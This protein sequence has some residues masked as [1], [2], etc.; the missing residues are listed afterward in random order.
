M[1]ASI[2]EFCLCAVIEL[3]DPVRKI[4]KER[5]MISCILRNVEELKKRETE[6]TAQ[7][8]EHLKFDPT[9]KKEANDYND[10]CFMYN[11]VHIASL[12]KIDQNLHPALKARLNALITQ[13][14][15]QM[16]PQP[17]AR[18][19]PVVEVKEQAS[20]PAFVTEIKESTIIRPIPIIIRQPPVPPA[21]PAPEPAP[22]A[23]EPAQAASALVELAAQIEEN[24]PKRPHEE[25]E[26]ERKVR[27]KI[28]PENK[29][30]VIKLCK[31]IV[32][33]QVP[34]DFR[35]TME[36]VIKLCELRQQYMALTS[37]K[38]ETQNAKII[39]ET[40]EYLQV[41]ESWPLEKVKRMK[42]MYQQ[43]LHGSKAYYRKVLA[44]IIG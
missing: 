14:R 26:Q 44:E 33:I 7:L 40:Q 11:I 43:R 30:E 28:T 34:S 29:D 17:A 12:L 20:A 41:Y 31:E 4:L 24:N 22:P 16:A 10:E 8:V 42:D 5:E 36:M 15:P 6:L 13:T 32:E 9:F 21:P 23:P 27:R 18:S 39:T 19:A 37:D 1:F 25:S 3:D 35:E 2:R 38:A